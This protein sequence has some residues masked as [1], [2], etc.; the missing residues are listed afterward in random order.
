[1]GRKKGEKGIGGE[2]RGDIAGLEGNIKG[3][4]RHLLNRTFTT[5]IW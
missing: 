3:E 1:M 4:L 5:A 2:E